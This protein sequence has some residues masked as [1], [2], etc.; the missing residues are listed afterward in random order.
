MAATG[1]LELPWVPGDT[2]IRLVV[3]LVLVKESVN[4]AAVANGVEVVL[5]W[6]ALQPFRSVTE[7]GRA[8]VAEG[9][10]QVRDLQDGQ[11]KQHIID[12]VHGDVEWLHAA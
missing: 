7:Q 3:E 5:A 12:Q 11:R 6:G 9:S 2:M 8:V 1:C 4:C 10:L